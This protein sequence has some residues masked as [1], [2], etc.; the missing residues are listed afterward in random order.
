[1]EVTLDQAGVTGLVFTGATLFFLAR[2]RWGEPLRATVQSAEVALAR[3]IDIDPARM[4]ALGIANALVATVATLTGF[5][6]TV[7]PELGKTF[8]SKASLASSGP[9]RHRLRPPRGFLTLLNCPTSR[10]NEHATT[11]TRWI[12]VNT[13]FIGAVAVAI[14]LVPVFG[15]T[16]IRTFGLQALMPCAPISA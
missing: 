9:E 7:Y 3:G 4:F 1:M 13:G 10:C 5:P 16:Y 8:I 15:S 2:T 14:A 12:G 11:G 6:Y